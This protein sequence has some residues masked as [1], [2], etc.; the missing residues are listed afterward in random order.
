[1]A[2]RRKKQQQFSEAVRQ[3]KV[4][5][6][7]ETKQVRPVT[8]RRISWTHILIL[9]AMSIALYG[10]TLRNGF[11]TDDQMQILKNPYVTEGHDLEKA[12]TGDVWAF[13]HGD[14]GDKAMGSN[15]YRPLQIW[16]YAAEY[17]I[18]GE[19]AWGWHL[20]NELLN[21]LVVT[22]VYLFLIAYGDGALAFWAALIFAL[23]PLHTEPVAW[24][25][26]LPE[27]QCAALLLASLVFYRRAKD[28]RTWASSSLPALICYAAA[29][30]TKEIALL[31][32][33]I[34][35]CEEILF[36]DSTLT[37]WKATALR[38]LPF[39]GLLIIYLAA[40]IHALG[41]FSPHQ[42]PTRAPLT[43]WDLVFAIPPIFAR[44][45]GK[46]VVPI[47]MNYFYGFK[48]TTEP[49][50]LFYTGLALLVGTISSIW[51]LRARKPLLAFALAWF[52]LTL[53]PS[54]S[55]NSVGENFFTDRYLYIPSIGFCILVAWMG[56]WVWRSSEEVWQKGCLGLGVAA[57]MLFCAVQITRRIP[58]FHDNFSLYLR[59]VQQSPNMALVQ[60]G[61]GAAYYDNG[62]SNGALEHGL[63][64]IAIN[65]QFELAQMNVAWYLAEQGKYDEAIEHLK[66]AVQ[67]HP[68]YVP[69][70]V[71][72]AKVYAQKGDWT[73]ARLCY[74]KAAQ[75][76]AM[77]SGYFLQLA[78]LAEMNANKPATDLQTAPVPSP[79]DFQTLVRLG[80]TMAQQGQ[81]TQAAELFRK[82]ALLQ[83]TDGKIG[84]KLGLS[85]ERAGKPGEAI[86]ILRKE[87]QLQP[88]S[89][90]VRGTLAE[91]LARNGR[92]AESNAELR[93]YLKKSPSADIAA[94]AHYALG[95]NA[96]KTGNRGEAL[97]EYQSALNLN[98]QFSQARQKV[99]EFSGN[100]GGKGP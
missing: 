89:W 56:L 76:D 95:L 46:L 40:R 22:L 25:A 84:V 70:L 75:L 16:I 28:G 58:V 4:S 27:L 78:R 9:V 23:H 17:A 92:M 87:A 94:Q 38:V 31:F 43:L 11:V 26:A 37:K 60:A 61:L 79:K 91:S 30:F 20:V 13:A 15:Y 44:Y 99:K 24:V 57:L 14:Y 53:V 35:I 12:F 21:A 93:D 66:I 69:P 65:P 85:L 83:P 34:L 47:D 1:V 88:D 42:Q 29:L 3:E 5:S 6:T 81:W 8:L 59:T 41:G 50:P 54:L 80:D 98:P 49:T 82:A 68:E 7:T 19:R 86:P 36:E 18:F 33:A 97:S 72:L 51:W 74:E 48:L 64:A 10:L 77:R 100:T 96:E 32:P 39:F 62:D 67:L 55:L 73:N 2:R 45:V 90:L 71:N 63:K 52:F